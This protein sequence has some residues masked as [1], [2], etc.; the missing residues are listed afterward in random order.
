MSDLSKV[1]TF[2]EVDEKCMLNVDSEILAKL[3]KKL[4]D[5]NDI[6]SQN[7]KL[8][9]LLDQSKSQLNNNLESFKNETEKLIAEAE[10]RKNE[11]LEL[12]QEIKSLLEEKSKLSRELIETRN[13]CEGITQQKELSEASKQDIVKLLDDKIADLKCCQGELEELLVTNKQLRQKNF[14]LETQLQ[15]QKS[16]QLHERS[17]AHRLSQE[18]ALLKSNNDWLA[19]E[20]HSKNLQYHESTATLNNDLEAAEVKFAQ[21][22]TEL[23]ISE[24][25]NKHLKETVMTLQNQL[26]EKLTSLK[27]LSDDFNFEK[28]EFTREMSIKQRMIDA[29]EKHTESLKQQMEE[30]KKTFSSPGFCEEE[31]KDMLDELN[32]AKSRLL[33]SESNCIK[34]QETVDH[35]TA[36]VSTLSYSATSPPNAVVPELYGDIGMLKKEL[37]QE[38][39]QKEEL[40]TQLEIFI[41]ELENKVPV[42]N[43]FRERTEIL[44][45]ELND[46]TLLLESTS[47]ER[48]EKTLQFQNNNLKLK[49]YE[50]QISTLTQQRI[51][52]ARQIQYLLVQQS[53]RNDVDGALTNA[54]LEFI[55]RLLNS[56]DNDNLSDTQSIITERLVVFKSSIELQK[57]NSELLVTIRN[58]ADELERAEEENR[59][60][61]QMLQGS[62]VA[63][64]KET[65]LAL[66][67]RA[68][69]LEKK[70]TVVMKERDAYKALTQSKKQDSLQHDQ[71]PNLSSDNENKL[72][73]LESKLSMVIDEADANSRE[74]SEEN[75]GLKTK[76]YHLTAQFESEKTSR[77]LAEDRVQLLQSTSEMSRKECQ[78]LKL[79]A[80]KL[81]DILLEQGNKAQL[82]IEALI[83]TKANFSSLQS[84][85][86]VIKADRDFVKK[87]HSDLKLENEQLHKANGDSNVLIAQLQVLQRERDQLLKET[88]QSFQEKISKLESDLSSLQDRLKEKSKSIE[89]S[90]LNHSSQFKWF[91]EKIDTLN[92][93]GQSA[94]KTIEENKQEIQS[95]KVQLKE[96]TVQ[97]QEAESRASSF[98]VVANAS[99]SRELIEN[100]R[101]EVENT[102]RKL[103]EAYSQVNY[104]KTSAE[105]SRS[106]VV[107]LSEAFEKAQQESQANLNS[108]QMERSELKESITS[109]TS[110]ITVLKK[111][112]AEM[113][114]TCERSE[115]E[116]EKLLNEMKILKSSAEDLKAEFK[117][118]VSNLQ[119][120]LN[121][122][123]TIA[124]DAQSSYEQEL[125][126]HAEV[127]KTVGSLKSELELYKSKLEELTAEANNAVLQLKQGEDIW[128]N[129]KD[130]Y[131]K[132]IV[133]HAQ[134]IEDLTTQNRLLFDQVELLSKSTDD[135]SKTGSSNLLIVLR[136]ERDVLETKL[137]VSASEQKILRQRLEIAKSDLHSATME[138]NKV[139]NVSL[140]NSKL[141]EEHKEIMEQL[142]QINVL[143]ESNTTLRN[144]AKHYQEEY[145]NINVQLE[146]C[147][148]KIDPLE[149]LIV[150]LKESLKVNEQALKL[151]KEESERWKKRS[152]DILQK[153]EKTDP[154]EHSKL[155]EEVENLKNELSNA[156]AT[157]EK[158]KEDRDEWESKFQRIRNQARDRLNSS[159][160]REVAL[161]NEI[162][163]LKE[164]KVKVE[165]SLQSAKIKISE[166][167]ERIHTLTAN[168]QSEND[169]LLDS[170][171]SLKEKL[172]ISENDMKNV[173]L[174]AQN[175]SA[176]LDDTS[177]ETIESLKNVV[178]TLQQE[179][180]NAKKQLVESSAPVISESTPEIIEK[181][182]T[183]FESEKEELIRKKEADLRANFEREKEETWKERE[184]A[185]QKQFEAKEAELQSKLSNLAAAQS[186]LPQS[187]H[188][189]DLG[190]MKKEWEQKY[191]EETLKRIK[192]AEEALKKRI[193]L[194]TQQKLEKIVEARKAVLEESFDERVNAK[195]QETLKMNSDHMSIEDHR[196]EI[197][198]LRMSLQR[199]FHSDLADIKQKAFEEGRQQASLKLKFL[200]TKIKNLEK[201]KNS[202]QHVQSQT[203]LPTFT[204][205]SQRPFT[206]TFSQLAA[207][208]LPAKREL[209]ENA[210]KDESPEKKMKDENSPA[211]TNTGDSN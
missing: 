115:S 140:Q 195:V 144:E 175:D 5:F 1:A 7:L 18:V 85:L 36:D 201:D 66:R 60:R 186:E 88:Q 137:E 190:V 151:S 211:T 116:I 117:T 4:T 210:L 31:R 34:L 207:S 184:S 102:N 171:N 15:S 82:T 133:S 80:S 77:T 37:I 51:D 138:L 13:R 187:A 100:L 185:L 131:E 50:K 150:S 177:K 63:E 198:E 74:W 164:S 181:L 178:K 95:L 134:K 2:L 199:Q 81:Q 183:E 159:K 107:E 47:R 86:N 103:N 25:T 96:K 59:V 180:S 205:G 43:S 68:E 48:D 124:K 147:K 108:L 129:Q 30:T 109:L 87:I 172:A 65:I 45:A 76:L 157:I 101:T 56:D 110:Q 154:E 52:L 24:A 12:E 208:T 94:L 197:E 67:D 62:T 16:D 26:Q 130:E 200:E 141:I 163:D 122:Q 106:S 44:E 91:Q 27:K 209:E 9:A 38:R 79:R 135:T 120:D 161:N 93:Q 193:R 99:D 188:E 32:D 10:V 121:L 69:T 203:Q 155:I 118:T 169:S 105:T 136:R 92:E 90:S 143:S 204:F 162:A 20:L 174:N 21:A 170:I 160:E 158:V 114:S 123:A 196:K 191:E 49:N 113:K 41:S 46:V 145:S 14:D 166:L 97:L 104:F 75:T 125:Q 112:K 78:E 156:A 40:K 39:L 54:E 55:K 28:Q 71:L 127:S 72:K 84:E 194:P 70:L 29:L 73:D 33:I 176:V 128:Q 192:D 35:L 173:L 58:L 19:K 148:K 22:E 182:K 153:Y 6:E 98:N 11:R 64:A 83:K 17:E 8:S 189:P 179:L 165:S 139:K 142:N 167:E 53:A 23:R 126:K 149:A 3:N 152:Q 119:K 42:L 111:E 57:K 89:E 61:V 132:R 206:G 146:E 168:F 202:E